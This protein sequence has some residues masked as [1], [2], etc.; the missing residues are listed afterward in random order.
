MRIGIDVRTVRSD[1]AGIG[2]Y[3]QCLVNALSGV[4]QGEPLVLF[5]APD[6]RWDLLPSGAGISHRVIRQKGAWWHL[7]AARLARELDVYHSPSSL[8]VP[9]L[10]GRRAV[11]TV[12]DL[13]PFRMPEVSSA[14]TWWTHRAFG[15]TLRRI[16]AVVAVSRH[17][18]SDLRAHMPGL[19][20]PVTVVHEAPR[21]GFVPGSSEAGPARYLLSVGTLEPRKNLPMLL[22]A[23]ARAVR[24]DPE[25]PE[26]VLVGKLGWKNEEFQRLVADPVFTGRIRLL[27]YVGDEELYRWFCGAWAFVFPSK[28]EGFGLPVLEAMACGVPVV[29][30]TG[31][32]LPEVAG[33]A[34]LFADPTDEVALCEQ[35]L[36]LQDPGVRA[37]YARRGL[38]RASRFSWETAARET[39]EVYHSLA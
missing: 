1:R 34:A 17:T 6:T 9:F 3:T 28:Y 39:L 24:K 15:A 4:R 20:T 19:R 32:S 29:T 26:L 27:G 18:E 14:K 2:I 36:Q 5:G 30:S 38:E 23:Y 21:P 12:H 7:E 33:E 10:L 22:R 13:V 11:V 16:G 25:L 37:E 8:F 31:S 35:L